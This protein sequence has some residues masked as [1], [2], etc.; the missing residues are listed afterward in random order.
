[1]FDLMPA[2]LGRLAL[3]GALL[4]VPATPTADPYKGTRHTRFLTAPPPWTLGRHASLF[5]VPASVRLGVPVGNETAYYYDSRCNWPGS[6][7]TFTV[8]VIY[9]DGTDS[10]PYYAGETAFSCSPIGNVDGTFAS[11]SYWTAC[12]QATGDCP[13]LPC[14]T[15]LPSYF[16]RG[17]SYV[18]NEQCY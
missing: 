7:D 17:P 8:Y 15:W 1:M 12:T 13:G 5:S 14:S 10:I 3:I 2:S 16:G 4:A 11:S 9:V 18:T 6:P